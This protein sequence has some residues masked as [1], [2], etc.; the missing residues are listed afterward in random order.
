[1]TILTFSFAFVIATYLLIT[2]HTLQIPLKLVGESDAEMVVFNF[3]ESDRHDLTEKISQFCSQHD[4]QGEYCAL[5]EERAI[6]MLTKSFKV[7]VYAVANEFS[8]YETGIKELEVFESDD[9]EVKLSTFC[10]TYNILEKDCSNLGETVRKKYNQ[11]FNKDPFTRLDAKERLNTIFTSVYDACYW[12]PG[13]KRG[14]ENSS[15]ENGRCSG[16]GSRPDA[17]IQLQ[18]FLFGTI[19]KYHILTFYDAACGAMAWMPNLLTK[20]RFDMVSDH[21]HWDSLCGVVCHL[22]LNQT[23]TADITIS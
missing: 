18:N 20:V 14:T 10:T 3:D 7:K 5:L 21:C 1:M 13:V 22:H 16:E 19:Q 6:S 23:V 4:V 11:V 2:I 15:S 9:L 12:E 8:S 17:T